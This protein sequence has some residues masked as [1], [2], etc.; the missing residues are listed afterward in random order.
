MID[1]V[2]ADKIF[3]ITRTLGDMEKRVMDF[4]APSKN[5][6]VL[7]TQL[8]IALSRAKD[9]AVAYKDALDD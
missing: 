8:W 6:D 3:A 9:A 4:P 1:P 2:I 7:R 5:T